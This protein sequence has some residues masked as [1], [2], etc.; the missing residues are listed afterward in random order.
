MADNVTTPTTAKPAPKAITGIPA[1]GLEVT[2]NGKVLRFVVEK[3]K[4]RSN[5]PERIALVPAPDKNEA[6][7]QNSVDW[8]GFEQLYFF[9][10]RVTRQMSV[11][12]TASNT[13]DN[14][15]FNPG[16]FVDSMAKFSARGETLKSLFAEREQLMQEM[17]TSSQ[18]ATLSTEDRLAAINTIGKRMREIM[19]ASAAKQEANRE[20][21]NE[22]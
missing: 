22:D 3:L 16:G 2:R 12:L 6:D 9:G 18:D 14:G 19:E 11:I 8:I 4:K 17:V 7:K 21:E 10:R 15:V 20:D 13:D 5:G 1:N